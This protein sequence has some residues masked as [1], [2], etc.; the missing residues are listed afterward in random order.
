MKHDGVIVTL[1][2]LITRK[3][4]VYFLTHHRFIVF[5]FAVTFPVPRDGGGDRSV[6][7]TMV[8]S[9]HLERDLRGVEINQRGEEKGCEERQS[10]RQI[11]K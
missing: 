4:H 10:V 3:I 1:T 7:A 5:F 2:I 8:I 11:N 6:G 9:L